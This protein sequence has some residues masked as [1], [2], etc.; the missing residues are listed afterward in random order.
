MAKK[1]LVVDDDVEMLHVFKKDLERYSRTFSVLT[2]EDGRTALKT[3]KMNPISLVVVD[4]EL[5][6]IGDLGL[7]DHLSNDY[8]EIPAIIMAG[9]GPSAAEQLVSEKGI[10]G[11]LKKPFIVED[12]AK[13]I[14]AILKK[15]AD[16]GVLHGIAPGTFLQLME[17]EQKTC[18]IRLTDEKSGRQGVLFFREGEVL[19]ARI[20]D[21]RGRDAAYIMLAWDEATLAI[22]DVCFVEENK[23]QA[24]LQ[25]LLLEAMRLKDE[26]EVEAKEKMTQEEIDEYIISVNQIEVASEKSTGEVEIAVEEDEEDEIEEYEQETRAEVKRPFPPAPV[27]EQKKNHIAIEG[28]ASDLPLASAGV[29]I[30]FSTSD[31]ILASISNLREAVLDSTVFTYLFRFFVFFAIT[32]LIAFLFLYSTME[33]NQDI[34]KQIGQARSWIKSRQDALTKVDGEIQLLYNQ[35]DEY[36][37]DNQSQLKIMELELKISELED[38]QDKIVTEIE[39][40]QKAIDE[41]QKR[42]DTLKEKGFFKRLMERAKKFFPQKT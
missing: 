20:E 12:L 25:G 42:L 31:N 1:V 18:T 13:K 40:Q 16:G 6:K 34:V 9:P 28:R 29:D 3:L 37:R 4:L 35:K 32:G 41:A 26:K 27:T 23:V 10:A 5:P 17:M 22:Q 24:D 14:T 7:L 38:K 2:A 15:E 21:Q 36:F 30:P 33:S 39:M 11:Y 19:D 8:P